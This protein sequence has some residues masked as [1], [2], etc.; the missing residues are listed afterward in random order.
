LLLCLLLRFQIFN[1]RFHLAIFVLGSAWTAFVIEKIFSKQ[2]VLVVGLLVLVAATPWFLFNHNKSLF[3]IWDTDGNKRIKEYFSAYPSWVEPVVGLSG[4]LRASGCRDIGL[5]SDEESKEYLLWVT[6]R[7]FKSPPVRMEH[8][9]VSNVTGRLTYPLGEFNPCALALLSVERPAMIDLPS[10]IYRRVWF[11]E[12]Q[13][14][15]GTS[16]LYVPVDL[17]NVRN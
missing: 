2:G 10:G 1:S 7:W 6:L 15:D 11:S 5:I 16:A 14:G 13:Q 12:A 3:Q 9:N 4:R 17:K 8:V